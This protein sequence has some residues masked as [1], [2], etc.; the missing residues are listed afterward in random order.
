MYKLNEYAVQ[1]KQRSARA[2]E[3]VKTVRSS[4]VEI[5]ALLLAYRPPLASRA[6]EWRAKGALFE[7]ALASASPGVEIGK[8]LPFKL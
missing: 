2:L 6:G 8:L 3:L 5:D 4:L 1:G 7:A